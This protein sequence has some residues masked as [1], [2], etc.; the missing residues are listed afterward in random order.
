MRFSIISATSDS[1]FSLTTHPL[2]TQGLLLFAPPLFDGTIP[3]QEPGFEIKRCERCD[4]PRPRKEI[5]T[6]SRILHSLRLNIKRR[7]PQQHDGDQHPSSDES[8]RSTKEAIEPLE[9]GKLQESG[10]NPDNEST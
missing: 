10:G 7:Q 3:D 8:K 9:F 1:N 6:Q 5:R 2:R 4:H